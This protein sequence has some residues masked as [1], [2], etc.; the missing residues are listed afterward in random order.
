MEKSSCK[1]TI[2]CLSNSSRCRASCGEGHSWSKG[3]P[4]PELVAEAALSPI[5]SETLLLGEGWV[6]QE[7]LSDFFVGFVGHIKTGHVAPLDVNII[8][9]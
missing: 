8:M 9:I 1:I 5:S 2:F 6:V 3:I 7:S 4:H